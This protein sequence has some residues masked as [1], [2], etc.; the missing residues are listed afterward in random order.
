MMGFLSVSTPTKHGELMAS[1]LRN[2]RRRRRKANDKK[3]KILMIWQGELLRTLPKMRRW[4][5]SS[6]KQVRSSRIKSRR[7]SKT[8]DFNRFQDTMMRKVCE[9]TG[10]PRRV[11]SR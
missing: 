4:R 6:A 11:L 2:R 9:A 1:L 10:I 7:V 3:F 5:N 8:D